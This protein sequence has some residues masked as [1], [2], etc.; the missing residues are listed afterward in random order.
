[1]RCATETTEDW[2]EI[3]DAD[4][5]RIRKKY[6]FNNAVPVGVPSTRLGDLVAKVATPIARALGLGCIDKRT[7]QLKP[8]SGC[9]KRKNWL[10]SIA[11]F[12][13]PLPGG[14]YKPGLSLITPTKDRPKAFALLEKW[15]ARQTVRWDQWVVVT[16]GVP[17]KL[18][19][20]QQLVRLPTMQGNSEQ[21]N[22]RVGLEAVEHNR[23]LVVQDDD[24]YA[25]RYIE[26][27][28]SW[29]D[30]AN[31]VGSSV[32]RLYSP[33]RRAFAV[34]E[35]PERCWCG[36]GQ[37]GFTSLVYPA[38][39]AAC[40]QRYIDQAIWSGWDGSQ[41]IGDGEV[42]HV[43]MKELP[44][45]ANSETSGP[46]LCQSPDR[47]LVVLRDWIGADAAEY[48]V[49]YQP[50]TRVDTAAPSRRET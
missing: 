48:A 3:S 41:K 27:M 9:A 5:R 42:L 30:Q 33:R 45:T 14:T 49:F 39:F 43:G 11:P 1:M 37:T 17:P 35:I 16:D 38:A 22:T 18:T 31:L 23:V 40:N 13:M 10:N 36:L 15:M 21:V 46:R 6:S 47:D 8:R 29:L 44:G 50:V 12:T 19:L 20:G 25:P 32:M 34:H 7:G 28:S 26:Q 24:W 4:R 2:I